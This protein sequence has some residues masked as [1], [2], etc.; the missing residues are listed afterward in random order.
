VFALEIY[1]HTQELNVECKATDRL[2]SF[3]GS[4]IIS[5]TFPYRIN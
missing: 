2:F 4:Y 5:S 3:S 1:V